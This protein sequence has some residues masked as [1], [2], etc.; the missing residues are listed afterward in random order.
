MSNANSI[1]LLFNKLWSN[2]SKLTPSATKIHNLLTNFGEQNILNDHIALRTCDLPGFGIKIL[3][4]VFEQYGYK[5]KQDYRFDQKKLNAVHLEYEQDL[6]NYPKVF[7]SELCLGEF[8]DLS[9]I[10]ELKKNNI[11][12]EKL[13]SDIFSTHLT[14]VFNDKNIDNRVLCGAPWP[15]DYNIYKKLSDISEYAGWLYA[16]GFMANHFT[17]SVNY[18]DKIKNLEELND[19]LLKNNFELNKSGGLIKGNKECFLEQSSTMADKVEVEFLDGQKH[20]IPCC[21]YEF[22]QR[23]SID[24]NN[25]NNLYQGFVAANADKIFVRSSK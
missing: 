10:G 18:L 14:P 11:N 15:K 19:L 3:A 8:S 5:I 20:F 17:I 13:F 22:A 7:I 21:F 2:Y 6:K 4:E 1:K 9:E 12:L 16:W 25:P 23:Y 24:I